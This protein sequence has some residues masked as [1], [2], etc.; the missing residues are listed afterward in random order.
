[1]RRLR[2]RLRERAAYLIVIALFWLALLLTMPDTAGAFAAPGA[3]AA[4][5][6]GLAAMA[7]CSFAAVLLLGD[8][9]LKN[10]LVIAL[11][12]GVFMVAAQ[13]FAF[14]ADEEYHFLRAFDLTNGRIL[15]A[16]AGGWVP[17]GY[18]LFS[19][20][21]RWSIPAAFDMPELWFSPVRELSFVARIR[22]AS[23][24]PLGYIPAAL[25]M[26]VGRLLGLSLVWIV[27]LGRLFTYLF[28]AGVC[29]LAISRTKALRSLVFL[30]A[31]S[32]GAFALAGVIT[33]DLPLIAAALLFVAIC[34]HYCFD[35]DAGE[36]VCTPDIALLMLSA[37]MI[38]SIKYFGYFLILPLLLFLPRGRCENKRKVL[39]LVAAAVLFI[40]AVQVFALLRYRGSVDSTG[41]A[42]TDSRAQIA[43]ILQNPLRFAATLLKDLLKYAYERLLGQHAGELEGFSAIGAFI[44][45]LPMLGALLAQD[46]PLLDDRARMRYAVFCLA[47]ALVMQA[48][49]CTALYVSW[50]PVGESTIWSA[51]PRYT[52]PF[53]IL[54]MLAVSMPRVRNEIKNWPRLISFLTLLAV[55]NAAA[56]RWLLAL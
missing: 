14:P 48:L 44:A 18:E 1:M 32:T 47:A 3:R 4:F 35:D 27:Y 22:S 29:V 7:L 52:L 8:S 33:L 31:L 54:I 43:Y 19:V 39:L 24:L 25:G 21:G 15:P 26:G 13:P 23:Y 37:A 55:T 40:A 28:Y 46:K 9:L 41:R 16:D 2:L 50:T 56:G 17:E 51:H 45:P 5:V 53:Y 6:F 49:C 30:A 12:V 10:F 20:R 42:D 36:R 38:V 11:L 34:F